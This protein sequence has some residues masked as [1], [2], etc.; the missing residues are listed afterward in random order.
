MEQMREPIVFVVLNIFVLYECV[1]LDWV[2][3]R[4]YNICNLRER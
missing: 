3:E 4:A 1:V 2:N